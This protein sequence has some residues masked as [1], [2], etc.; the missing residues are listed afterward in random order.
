MSF[1]QSIMRNHRW[2]GG[3]LLDSL[4][5]PAAAIVALFALWIVT[6]PAMDD[7]TFGYSKVEY[8]SSGRKN[9]VPDVLLFIE[10]RV[11]S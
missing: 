11:L 3:A 10:N 1:V 9:P 6:R 4:V 5:N 2:I 8:F 7:F